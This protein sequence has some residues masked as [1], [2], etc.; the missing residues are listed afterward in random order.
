M[1]PTIKP[2]DQIYKLA[3]EQE[4]REEKGGYVGRYTPGHVDKIISAIL[5][6]LDEQAAKST[7]GE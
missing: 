4:E 7:K 2:S 1:T 3:K 6:Y 5:Q